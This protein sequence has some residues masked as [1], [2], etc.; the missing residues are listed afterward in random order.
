[1]QWFNRILLA[2]LVAGLVAF[3]PEQLQLA[4]QTDDL[5]RIRKERSA[6][7]EANAAL[8][9]DIRRLRAEVRALSNDPSEVARIAREDLNLVAPGEIVFEV[10]EVTR[11]VPRAPEVPER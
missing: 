5:A 8:K 1:M 6:L 3:V 9:D 2:V 7:V 11:E 10:E 4:A